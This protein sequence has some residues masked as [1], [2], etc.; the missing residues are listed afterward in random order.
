MTGEMTDRSLWIWYG[1]GS[2]GKSMVAKLLKMVLGPMYCTVSRDVMLKNHQSSSSGAA[3]PHLL[4]LV[5]ARMG[6]FA[7]SE[8]DDK[9]NEALL[10]SIS[11]TD[12]ITVRALYGAQFEFN[13]IV[14]MFRG[15]AGRIPRDGG[16]R[17][18]RPRA[19]APPAD[20]YKTAA[21]NK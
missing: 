1:Q 20:L 14:V 15:A 13:P 4:P 18:A 16:E 5:V 9:L 10:K 2:N 3:T 6:M 19:A 12:A 21:S 11:G 17:S 7:E 8:S